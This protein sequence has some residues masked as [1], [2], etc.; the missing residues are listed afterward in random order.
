[1]PNSSRSVKILVKAP[2][3]MTFCKVLKE[4]FLV[5]RLDIKEPDDCFSGFRGHTDLHTIIYAVFSVLVEKG[6][7]KV[8][9]S[10]LH[11]VI[12]EDVLIRDVPWS[13]LRRKVNHVSMF[14]K[15]VETF[16]AAL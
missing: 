6:D 3:N 13:I 8:G 1:M 5:P 4:P 10:Y 9:V 7:E 12:E 11:E 15:N 16:D 2:L 14:S